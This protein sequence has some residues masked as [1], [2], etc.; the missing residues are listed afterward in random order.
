M[1]GEAVKKMSRAA[2]PPDPKLMPLPSLGVEKRKR[3]NVPPPAK[4]SAAKAAPI[5]RESKLWPDI[6]R[7]L[8]EGECP[9]ETITEFGTR[10]V[11][12]NV[13]FCYAVTHGWFTGVFKEWPLAQAA[14]FQYKGGYQCGC[15][16]IAIAQKLLG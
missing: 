4:F 10:P 15:E 11:E 12:D 1:G 3:E 13:E 9:T 14:V 7:R 16:S 5:Y 6:K 8:E 2:P